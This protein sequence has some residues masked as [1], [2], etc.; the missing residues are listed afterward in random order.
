MN[1]SL[2]AI[3]SIAA[4]I[5][6]LFLTYNASA[7]N[8][9]GLTKVGNNFILGGTLTQNTT[10]DLGTSYFL[11]LSKSSQDYLM[12]TNGG[13]VGIGLSSPSYLLDVNGA[14]RIGSLTADPTGA[15]GVL[16]Y[17]SSTNKLKAYTGGAWKDVLM[18]GD[19]S[20]SNIPVNQIAYGN[21]SGITSSSNFTYDGNALGLGNGHSLASQSGAFIFNTASGNMFSYRINGGLALEVGTST[22]V[23][24]DLNTYSTSNG[25]SVQLKAGNVEPETWANGR[26]QMGYSST[27]NYGWIQALNNGSNLHLQKTGGKVLLGNTTDQGD[28]KLQV[29]GNIWNNT[30]DNRLGSTTFWDG[31]NYAGAKINV[32]PSGQGADLEFHQYGSL[33]GKVGGNHGVSLYANNYVYVTDATGTGNGYLSNSENT[34]HF[35]GPGNYKFIWQGGMWQVDGDV[36]LNNIVSGTPQGKTYIKSIATA[37]TAPVTTGTTKMV[38]TD[39]NGLLSYQDIPS[40]G[41]G[42]FIQNQNVSAQTGN[43]KISGDGTLNLLTANNLHVGYNDGW[44]G[45]NTQFLNKVAFG[46]SHVGGSP[47]DNYAVGIG[48][49]ENGNFKALRLHINTTGFPGTEG[50]GPV[51]EFAGRAHGNAGTG[52]AQIIGYSTNIIHGGAMNFY[53]NREYGAY[54]NMELAMTLNDQQ[55]VVV[56]NMLKLGNKNSDPTATN[57]ALFYNSASNNFRGYKDGA[58]KNFLM[59]GDV[60]AGGDLSLQANQIAYGSSSN[61]MTSN[62]NFIYDPNNSR[63]QLGSSTVYG[64]NSLALQAGT[65]KV[66]TVNSE[67][68]LGVGMDP[69]GQFPQV[70]IYDASGIRNPLINLNTEATLASIRFKNNWTISGSPTD[71]QIGKWGTTEAAR[72]NSDGEFL[73][74]S[75]DQGD[76]KLQVGGTSYLQKALVNTNSFLGSEAMRVGGTM[77][78][79]DD[80]T[81]RPGYDIIAGSGGIHLSNG[82]PAYMSIKPSGISVEGTTTSSLFKFNG[83]YTLGTPLFDINNTNSWGYTFSTNTTTGDPNVEIG[84]QKISI[85]RISESNH[86]SSFGVKASLNHRSDNAYGIYSDV[87]NTNKED[88]APGTGPSYALY[89]ERG[90]V[91]LGSLASNSSLPEQSGDIHVITVDANGLL[92]HKSIPSGSGGTVSVNSNQV[93]FGGTGNIITSND[94]LT[95]NGSTFAINAAGIEAKK[96]SQYK[97]AVNGNAIF[98]R[99]KVRESAQWPDY[100][101]AY[102]YKLRSLKEIEA[103]IKQH[104]HLPEVPSA[105]KVK[106]EGIDIGDNQAILL[107]KIEELTLYAIEQSKEIETLKA[108]NQTLTQKMEK[109]NKLEQEIEAIKSLLK[110]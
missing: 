14:I 22:M 70:Q 9:N 13:N 64:A 18:Q 10:I 31:S 73:I 79:G 80:W 62:P 15:N 40:G 84:G 61:I 55:E 90:L 91:R 56:A 34:N 33:T 29:G 6:V 75:S 81:Y 101:F 12:V 58:W 47:N 103:F 60:I 87:W 98:T 8:N 11:K 95:Y 110:K 4:F 78:V 77:V 39:D 109:V 1:K 48:G 42:S 108:Q 67:G 106:K 44:W 30:A 94:N 35:G 50:T 57:G 38:V 59:E 27:G 36:S 89:T 54:G 105:E 21:G 28:Y 93:A 26:L 51:L 52:F 2:F 102:N 92:G 5:I 100:V 69:S 24:G 72:F 53:T 104:K 23:Y 82:T 49:G 83:A 66:F 17:N 25:Q 97:L 71:F 65:S 3:K 32:K 107:K 46:K 74:N 85:T 19:V 88:G 20:S 43:F 99:V 41:S 76:Y 63:L 16:Y 96:Y 68:Q 37:F 7:Q 86:A 45:E